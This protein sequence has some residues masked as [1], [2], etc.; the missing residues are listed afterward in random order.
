[1]K[2][3]KVLYGWLEASPATLKWPG[4]LMPWHTYTG[5]FDFEE[6]I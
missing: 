6:K 4:G 1:M 2:I 3:L 5:Q